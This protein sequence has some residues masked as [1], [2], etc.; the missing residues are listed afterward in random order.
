MPFKI[1]WNKK[2]GITAVEY[3]VVG[4]V[5]LFSAFFISYSFKT[6]GEDIANKVTNEVN[7]ISVSV[8]NNST[9]DPSLPDRP[10]ETSWSDKQKCEYYGGTYTVSCACPTGRELSNGWCLK[11]SNEGNDEL[12]YENMKTTCLAA[13]HTWDEENRKCIYNAKEKCEYGFIWSGT[14]CVAADPE[15]LGDTSKFAF[16]LNDDET[17]YIIAGVTDTAQLSVPP[18]YKSLPVVEI[19]TEAFKTAVSLRSI[20]IPAS[21]T[22]IGTSA[23][24]GLSMLQR[25]DIKAPI[26]TIEDSAF[27]GCTSLTKINLENATM[28]GT[29]AFSGC[30]ALTSVDLSKVQ[31]LKDNAFLGCTALSSINTIDDIK[32]VGASAFSGCK[33]LAFT[34]EPS[35]GFV[36][37]GID[38]F[39]NVPMTLSLDSITSIPEGAF[40]SIGLDTGN[41]IFTIPTSVTSIGSNAFAGNT[42]RYIR[43]P[44]GSQNNYNNYGTTIFGTSNALVYIPKGTYETAANSG[45][46]LNPYAVWDGTKI[47]TADYKIT[48]SG[49]FEQYY[50][51]SVVDDTPSK[52]TSSTATY[53]S[54]KIL[55]KY[56][57]NI[58][59]LVVPNGAKSLSSKSIETYTYV[60][61]T[62]S[63]TYYDYT[64]A[65]AKL[66]IR[67]I[68]FPPSFVNIGASGQLTNGSYQ[69]SDRD[70]NSYYTW[71]VMRDMTV[72]DMYFTNKNAGVTFTDHAF[73]GY[74]NFNYDSTERRKEEKNPGSI[75]AATIHVPQ[76]PTACQKYKDTINAY[77][78]TY[79]PEMNNRVVC[80]VTD[81]MI[82]QW[83][84]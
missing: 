40:A 59:A 64:T 23:F 56:Q 52:E 47:P 6:N 61:S 63:R 54:N 14:T 13:N 44:E 46:P 11:K 20:E 25:V 28:I 19:G 74:N 82:A 79:Y 80:D 62:S 81:D 34:W 8:S 1:K 70:T 27:Q 65:I 73:S 41:D 38:S 57:Y 9:G 16:I 43:L 66:P 69:E 12:A 50:R 84:N 78:G 72:F 4:A 29:S 33:Q 60:G 5:V 48:S 53:Y 31:T 7:H 22:K 42:F 71:G 55:N 83:Y 21:V 75:S 51:Y 67:M 49:V 35:N 39:K 24:S 36:K 17:G 18:T 30:S 32:D 37:A 15:A 45:R 26:I 68:V 77:F 2:D 3:S 76:D 10:N 58:G